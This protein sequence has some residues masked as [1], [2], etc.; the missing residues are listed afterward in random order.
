VL[1]GLDI[2]AH[3]EGSWRKAGHDQDIEDIVARFYLILMTLCVSVNHHV[4]SAMNA[5]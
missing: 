4:D 2:F 3:V 5:V 1:A